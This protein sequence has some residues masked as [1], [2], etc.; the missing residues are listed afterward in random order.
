[1]ALAAKDGK[2]GYCTLGCTQLT[3]DEALL[4]EPEG[5]REQVWR[6]GFGW[7]DRPVEVEPWVQAEAPE[8]RETVAA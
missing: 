8:Y 3:A 4:P 1:M 6:D 5:E 7:V 2:G